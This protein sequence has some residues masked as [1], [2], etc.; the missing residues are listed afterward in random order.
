MNLFKVIIL[1]LF[2]GLSSVSYSQKIIEFSQYTL[3][4]DKLGK[5]T[6]EIKPHIKKSNSENK[7]NRL[8]GVYGVLICYSK[9]GEK[10]VKRQDM[11]NKLAKTGKFTSN[12]AYSSKD[13]IVINSV[14]YFNMKDI[15]E[16]EY[17]SK[18]KC[19]KK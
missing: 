7:Y 17:P 1:F 11:T 19:F 13:I 9:N 10:K 4:K 2:C 6:I 12:L 15:K 16:E 3:I 14:E 8:F 5:Q 18:E